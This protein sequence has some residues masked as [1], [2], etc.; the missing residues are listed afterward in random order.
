MKHNHL[1]N[2]LSSLLQKDSFIH[3]EPYQELDTAD[4]DSRLYTLLAFLQGLYLSVSTATL[5]GEFLQSEVVHVSACTFTTSVC[6]VCTYIRI[7]YIRVFVYC[8]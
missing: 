7:L 2:I 1:R 8:P 4:K 6:T 5:C 3:F